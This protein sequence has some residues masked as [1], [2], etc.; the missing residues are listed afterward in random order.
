MREDVDL[1]LTRAP[2][3]VGPAEVARVSAMLAPIR[4][5]GGE[6]LFV[7]LTCARATLLERV[8]RDDR[9]AHDKLTDPAVLLA[10]YELGA[11]LPFAPQ[12]ALDVTSVPP[13]AAAARIA[14]HFALAR[15][16]SSEHERRVAAGMSRR[17][18]A[19]GAGGAR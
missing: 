11:T 14:A 13:M 1:I 17:G 9:R 19:D 3:D 5:A 16:T 8:G 6:V 15:P 10:R 7:R 12:L 4:D 2:R 18:A